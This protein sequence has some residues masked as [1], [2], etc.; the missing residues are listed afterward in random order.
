[1]IRATKEEMDSANLEPNVRDLCAHATINF[2][3]CV[4]ANQPF[5]YKCKGLWEE[6]DQC[7][8]QER[9]HDMKEFER[10]KRLNR[11]ERRLREAAAKG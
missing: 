4:T 8:I 11:R 7:Y 3:G 6:V 9:V 10:E 5:W 2:R 1:M